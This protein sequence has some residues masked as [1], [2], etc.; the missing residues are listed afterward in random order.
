MPS[1]TSR[2]SR[3]CNTT[4]VAPP[5]WQP[6][7]KLSVG[8]SGLVIVGLSGGLWLLIMRGVSWVIS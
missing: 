5:P 8:A 7:D 6:P 3:L 4:Y 2:T 1:A